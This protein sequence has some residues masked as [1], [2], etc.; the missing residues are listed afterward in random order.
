MASFSLSTLEIVYGSSG[1]NLKNS[2]LIFSVGVKREL[3][4]FRIFPLY[5][6]VLLWDMKP[7]LKSSS[8]HLLQFN[9]TP[10]IHLYKRDIVPNLAIKTE[11]NGSFYTP[12]QKC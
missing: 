3:Y 1:K 11:Y 12:V 2:E 6:R 8:L 9:K 4:I 10:V 5:K 7:R